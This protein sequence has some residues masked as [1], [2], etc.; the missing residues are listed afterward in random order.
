MVSSQNF[1]EMVLILIA[2]LLLRL[3]LYYSRV[4]SKL[5]NYGVVVVG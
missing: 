1:H 2:D 3:L 5:R 4:R